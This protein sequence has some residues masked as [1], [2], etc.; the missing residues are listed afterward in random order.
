MAD[1]MDLIQQREQEERDRHISNARSK[2]AAVS[3]SSVMPA[4]PHPRSTPYC[5]ARR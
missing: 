4:A 5:R 2:Q 3:L 1:A